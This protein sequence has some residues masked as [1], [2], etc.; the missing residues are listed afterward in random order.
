MN[1]VSVFI[2]KDTYLLLIFQVI[3]IEMLYGNIIYSNKRFGHI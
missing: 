1:V 2:C 3:V